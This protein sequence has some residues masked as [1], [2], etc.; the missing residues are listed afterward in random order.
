MSIPGQSKL[1]GKGVSIASRFDPIANAYDDWYDAPEGSA[2]F[3]EEVECLRLLCND[4]SGCWLELGVGTGRFAKAIGITHGIDLSPQ[5]AAK[6]ARRGV[7][8]CIGRAEQLPYSNHLFDGVLMAL[9]LC[10]LEN[11]EKAFLE[12]A[13]ALR[14]NGSLVLGTVPAESPWGRA[15]M[16]KG[17]SGH[18][19]YAYARFYTI[20]ETIELIEKTGFTLQRG[21]SALFEEPE[22][23]SPGRSRVK[24]G[25]VAEAGFIGLLF[26]AHPAGI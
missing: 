5:M 17:A 1:Q 3:H 9:T 6:A 8:A 11:P 19:V 15:Y 24:A 26:D 12:C 23:G 18:P 4:F 14:E 2:I 22:S 21:C 20:V 16:R 10:F 13:R 7:K 25:I